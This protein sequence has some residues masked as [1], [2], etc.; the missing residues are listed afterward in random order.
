MKTLTTNATGLASF[1]AIGM[2]SLFTALAAGP[3]NAD[4][5]QFECYNNAITLC[6]EGFKD[7]TSTFYAAGGDFNLCLVGALIESCDA[8]ISLYKPEMRYNGVFQVTFKPLNT[9]RACG[10]MLKYRE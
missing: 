1:L 10:V 9:N 6:N 7:D 2:T 3:V 4:E 8:R 5:C